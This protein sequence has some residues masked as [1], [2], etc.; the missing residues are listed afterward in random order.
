MLPTNQDTVELATPPSPQPE[1]S[2][3]PDSN[4]A[5]GRLLAALFVA[6][7]V[8]RFL[9]AWL[10]TKFTLVDDA[11]I[12]LRY[13]RNL[14]EQGT[15]VY[16]PGEAVFGLTSPLYG[17][18]AACL[19]F[20]FGSHIEV[21]VIVFNILLWTG[22]GVLIARELPERSRL[23]LMALFLL[24][25]V[26]V[27]NQMLGMETP[28]LVLLLAGSVRAARL[29][30]VTTACLWFGPALIT[31]PEAVLLSPFLL[32]LVAAEH[33]WGPGMK[34]MLKP[35][36]LVA[37]LTPGVL[38]VTFALIQYGS[39]IP[40][41]MVAKTGWGSTHYDSIFTLQNAILTVPRLSFLPFIDGFPAAIQWVLAA[42]LLLGVVWIVFVNL[43]RGTRASR[44]WLGFYAV[45]ITFFLVGKGA[46]EAS[47][48][49]V[50]SSVALLCAAAPCLPKWLT[51]PG[52]L[53]IQL[54]LVLSLTGL[55]FVA[56]S[57]RAPLLQYYVD[58][59]GACAEFLE[60]RAEPGTAPNT[61]V[62]IGEIGVFGFRT[63][64]KVV[65][66]AALI[67]PETLP[68][69]NDGL[70]FI[71]MVQLS[72]SKYFVLSDRAV[73]TNTYPAIAAV[74]IGDLE[75]AWFDEQCQHIA[76]FKDKHVY[77]VT[78]SSEE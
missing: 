64:M 67:S 72:G 70:S 43:R 25:P 39:L 12:H 75:K 14:A 26:F 13:A 4:P 5:A 44:T 36:A 7:G 42:V 76:Q 15:F 78:N 47:W 50:P 51:N 45:Y 11:Y 40:Q 34:R 22:A 77:E 52:Q 1:P 19:Y 29:G 38:W 63:T 6:S 71:R 10:M 18:V 9:V 24:A 60:A 21:A 35:G 59:Y 2:L 74:W 33:G 58:G 62:A 57:Q 16:N 3:G 56:A 20:V 27:D 69:R 49:A 28:L 37:L 65:D 46:T 23:P 61:K 31:R 8:F 17:L 41:S 66:V 48:Y 53:R 68:W 32:M 73:T 55:S 54:A 30:N